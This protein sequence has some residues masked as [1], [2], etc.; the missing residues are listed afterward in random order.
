MVYSL[1]KTMKVI[2][3]MKENLLLRRNLLLKVGRL[4]VN[5]GHN[6]ISRKSQV[7]SLGLVIIVIILVLVGTFAFVIMSRQ[8]G[9]N[10]EGQ[11]LSLNANNLREVVLKTELCGDV[12]SQA[13][14]ISCIDEGHSLCWNNC[15]RFKREI[16]K[17]IDA[18]IS[19]NV[20]YEF[21]I[22][23]SVNPSSSFTLSRGACETD[24]S[25]SASQHLVSGDEIKVILC[26][27]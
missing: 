16:K 3:T 26:F 18:S 15:E 21:S 22:L 8:N 23:S 27:S 11:Y 1:I 6:Q 25:S 14:I 19:K 12:S 9:D 13:E 10:I 4:S 5:I 24:K 17:I 20:N 2:K 7:E